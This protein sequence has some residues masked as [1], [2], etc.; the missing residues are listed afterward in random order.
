[1]EDSDYDVDPMEMEMDSVLKQIMEDDLDRIEHNVI[2]DS[3]VDDEH[4]RLY[5]DTQVITM[6]IESE[7]I[8]DFRKGLRE[9][10]GCLM[11]PDHLHRLCDKMRRFL[12][13]CFCNGVD[14][15][16]V[17]WDKDDY[18][19]VSMTTLTLVIHLGDALIRPHSLIPLSESEQYTE[20]KEAVGSAQLR[21]YNIE[22][23]LEKAQFY[24]M[25]KAMC[26]YATVLTAGMYPYKCW[27]FQGWTQ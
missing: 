19:T 2:P 14:Y 23:I 24:R 15:F 6:E 21:M 17:E 9:K 5:K 25:L 1:M 3:H 10:N 26:V 20:L 7:F 16:C 22:T 4:F 18:G 11:L 8:D 27:P 13:T 12:Y